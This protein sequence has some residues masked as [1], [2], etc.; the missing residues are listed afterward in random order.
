MELAMHE[1]YNLHLY[2]KTTEES[3]ID[4][5][6]LQDVEIFYSDEHETY[7]IFAKN[8]LLNFDVLKFLGDYKDRKSVV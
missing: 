8:A 7:L 1:V 5:T 3:L 6:S 2:D 4:L